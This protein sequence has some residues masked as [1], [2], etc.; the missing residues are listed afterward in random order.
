MGLGEDI[1]AERL[2]PTD[3]AYSVVQLDTFEPP[4]SLDCATKCYEV[5][6]LSE[7]NT[8]KQTGTLWIAYDR[9]GKGHLLPL[10]EDDVE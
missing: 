8:P 2:L 5:D 1:Q 6:D 10:R 3:K 9:D 7:V 4:S